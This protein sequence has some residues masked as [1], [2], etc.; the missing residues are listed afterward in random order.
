MAY[1]RPKGKL[2]TDA[3][4]RQ[5]V[6]VSQRRS[7]GQAELSQTLWKMSLAGVPLEEIAPFIRS[8][9]RV[10][11]AKSRRMEKTA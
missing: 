9:K 10:Q 7:W 3:W 8:W 1:G 6:A 11:T 2:H 4:Y 5:I